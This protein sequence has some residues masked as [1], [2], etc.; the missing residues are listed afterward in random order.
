MWGRYIWSLSRVRSFGFSS[1]G[2]GFLASCLYGACVSGIYTWELHIHDKRWDR[3]RVISTTHCG[4]GLDET[5]LQLPG[6][7]PPAF[8]AQALQLTHLVSKHVSQ[9]THATHRP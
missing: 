5:P 2:D 9:C 4:V 3:V 6:L 8:H 7:L 1:G